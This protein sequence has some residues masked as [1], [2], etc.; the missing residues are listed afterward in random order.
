M[1]EAANVKLSVGLI[2]S[3]SKLSG[4]TNMTDSTHSLL[5]PHPG[6]SACDVTD[7]KYSILLNV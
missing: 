7:A 1:P 3:K 5:Y 6:H 4:S 2:S